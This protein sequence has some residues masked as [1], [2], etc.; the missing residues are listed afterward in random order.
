LLLAELLW[1][2]KDQNPQCDA[3]LYYPELPA[4]REAANA[5]PGRATGLSCL[6]PLLLQQYGLSDLRGYDAVDPARISNLLIKVKDPQSPAG[7]P[8]WYAATQWWYPSLQLVDV[9]RKFKLIPIL[10]ALNLRYVI[11][12]GNPPSTPRFEP[13]LAHAEGYWVY[14]NPDVLPRAYVPAAVEVLKERDAFRRITEFPTA[15]EFNPRELAYV[16]SNPGLP[17]H[18]SG[19]AKIVSDLPSEVHV[20]VD[21]ETPGLLVLADQWYSG[22]RA[23]VNG[24]ETPIYLVNAVVRGVKVP[25]GKGEVVFRYEPAGWAR[26]LKFCSLATGIL[27]FWSALALWLTRR[28]SPTP[29]PV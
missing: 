7:N 13:L 15:F 5:P 14:E 9:N 12:M 28:T 6:P 16:D 8:E 10:N 2:A 18:C 11:G 19:T 4:L 20:S 21:M 3:S 22:W 23:F 25:A 24:D 27:I 1:F 29:V 17:D 26:G